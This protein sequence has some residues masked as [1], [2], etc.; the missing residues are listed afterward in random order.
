MHD[1]LNAWLLFEP[2]PTNCP[3][4]EIVSRRPDGTIERRTYREVGLRTQQLMHALDG[5]GLDPSRPVATLAWNGASHL[6]AYLAVPCTGRILH[7]LNVRLSPEE[8]AFILEDAN[9][10]A[11]L[12][13]ADFLP[14]LDRVQNLVAW[15]PTATFTGRC[16]GLQRRR[17]VP[18]WRRRHRVPK[19][20]LR[21]RRPDQG[22]HQ[23]R[24]RMDILGRPRSSHHE[25]RCRCR[26]SRHR[27][28]RR[29]LTR[30]PIGVRRSPAG[31]RPDGF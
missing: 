4:A 1:Q 12:V 16:R 9:D 31:H 25:D 28:A 7:T 22:P 2:G 26:G 27:G 5:L 15:C 30:A 10:Q 21:H 8:L 20:L 11:V 13:D 24:R 18:Y 6:E 29:P 17:L 23:V 3:D 14:L 19:W